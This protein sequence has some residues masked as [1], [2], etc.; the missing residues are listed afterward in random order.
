MRYVLDSCV[1]LK[2]VLPETDSDKAFRLRSA[3]QAGV[4]ELLAPNI[5]VA[6]ANPAVTSTASG[7]AA[8]PHHPT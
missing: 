4:H 7:V 6:S 5:Y 3:A 2:W 1:A 8:S